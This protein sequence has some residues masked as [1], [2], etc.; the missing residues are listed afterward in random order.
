[1]EQ[2]I[3]EVFGY[4]VVVDYVF[5]VLLVLERALEE[6]ERA[7]VCVVD[8]VLEVVFER[9]AQFVPVVVLADLELGLLEV[10]VEIGE[11]PGFGVP[12]FGAALRVRI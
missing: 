12:G 5:G 2:V 4:L 6:V 11:G 3:S 8:K 1:M 10:L 7:V 9:D